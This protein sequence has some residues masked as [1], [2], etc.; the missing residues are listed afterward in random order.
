[1]A[2]ATWSR[3]DILS[4]KML[5]FHQNIFFYFTPKFPKEKQFLFCIL[6]CPLKSTRYFSYVFLAKI[7]KVTKHYVFI[8]GQSLGRA[9]NSALSH[10]KLYKKLK[11][12]WSI[13]PRGF[14]FFPTTL[15]SENADNAVS[16]MPEKSSI[17]IWEQILT[18]ILNDIFYHQWLWNQ[19][20]TLTKAN[21]Q[22]G[23]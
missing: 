6:R 15:I 10:I 14:S 22:R 16:W 19:A 13:F 23:M 21:Q 8:K 9:N 7:Q 5:E 2:I 3:R 1:M 12:T 11:N 20:C 17:H 4:I 18:V